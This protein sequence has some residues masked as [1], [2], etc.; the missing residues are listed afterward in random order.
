MVCHNPPL[1]SVSF[2]HGPTRQKDTS[3][4]IRKSKEFTVNI[5]S[6]PFVEGANW[7]ATD[8]PVGTEEWTGSGLTKVKST[9]VK[10]PRVGESAFSME[11]ELYHLQ[12]IAPAGKPEFTT[13]T[14]VLGLVKAVHVR[15]D[16]WV[17]D[18]KG[19]G[20][21]DP[22]KFRAVSRMGGLTFARIG[23]GFELPRAAWSE[24]GEEIAK[25]KRE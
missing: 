16:V 17:D 22:V 18:G 14:F 1:I 19:I 5:I 24:I 21:M 2:T 10:P 7:T 11:C 8:A 4:N 3:V 6:E 23:E 20:M 9:F 15:K 12:D 13:C 25:L